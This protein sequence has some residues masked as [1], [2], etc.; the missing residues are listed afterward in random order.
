MLKVGITGGIGSGKSTV[1]QVFETLGIPV[2]YADIAARSVTETVPQVVEQVKQLF[3]ADIYVNNKLDRQRVAS[4]VFADKELLQK[5]NSII[6]P[7]T[8]A[9]GKQ[10]LESQSTP[11]AIKE[12]AIFFESGSN[13]DMDV[14]IGVY[15]PVDVRIQRIIERDGSTREKVLDRMSTQ[16]NEDEK[17]KLCDHI[18]T[19]DGTVAIIPQVLALHE[20]LLAHAK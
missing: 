18:I 15:A 20:V 13:K 8:I 6:H 17:M 12:A 11:Y 19:N 14:M 9:Y 2:F 1:C 7:A 16:M 4:L 5:L 10:W 3:G